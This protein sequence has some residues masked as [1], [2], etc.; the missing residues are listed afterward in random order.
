[1][2]VKGDNGCLSPMSESVNYIS[3]G[4]EY[5]RLQPNPVRDYLDLFWML[6]EDVQLNARIYS[7][8]G[9]QLINHLNISSGQRI[10]VSELQ[11]GLYTIRLSSKDGKRS[12]VYRFVK[13]SY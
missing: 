3:G 9:L 13:S 6:R 11:P 4:G 2:Q 8:S 7:S 5:V 12:Y 1:V 10:S